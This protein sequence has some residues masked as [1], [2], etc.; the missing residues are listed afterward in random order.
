MYNKDVNFKELVNNLTNLFGEDFCR[1]Y[2]NKN[3][4]KDGVKEK[5]KNIKDLYKDYMSHYAGFTMKNFEEDNGGV[6]LTYLVPGLTKEDIEISLDENVC[7]VK[8]IKK[9][10]YFGELDS[11]VKM[12]FDVDV[13]KTTCK[14][15]NGVLKIC[16]YRQKNESKSIKINII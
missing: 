6:E 4:Q 3:N 14:L 15:E 7:I 2:V 9:V 13:E 8:S 5:N 16:L 10:P 1:Y 12:K 11:K